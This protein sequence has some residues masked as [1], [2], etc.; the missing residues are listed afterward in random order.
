MQKIESEKQRIVGIILKKFQNAS[1][2]EPDAVLYR[3]NRYSRSDRATCDNIFPTFAQACVDTLP[4]CTSAAAYV[5]PLLYASP[6][7]ESTDLNMVAQ[8]DPKNEHMDNRK[9]FE[10][11]DPRSPEKEDELDKQWNLK[12]KALAASAARE[13][14]RSSR[15][16]RHPVTLH[17]APNFKR[18]SK[19]KALKTCC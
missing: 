14:P 19:I 4:A 15:R 18:Q 9:R 7:L 17:K 16:E 3:C 8:V 12:A 5:P 13:C 2:V 1:A 6:F 11:Y 10:T